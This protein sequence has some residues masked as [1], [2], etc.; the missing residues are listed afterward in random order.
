MKLRSLYAWFTERSMRAAF[1]KKR[2]KFKPRIS[3]LT[4]RVLAVNSISLL[5]LFAGLL[6]M[7]QYRKSLLQTEIASLTIQARIF[8]DT[9]GELAVEEIT[10]SNSSLM[11]QPARDVI[12]RI[13][14]P[15]RARARLFDARGNLLIDSRAMGGR[16]GKSNSIVQIEALRKDSPGMSFSLSRAIGNALDEIGMQTSWSLHHM[17]VYAERTPQLAKD[18]AEVADALSGNIQ[19]AVRRL[20]GDDDLIITVAVPVQHYKQV[21]GALMVSKTGEDIEKIMGEVWYAILQVFLFALVVTLLLS[22]YLAGTLS[23]PMV[24]LADAANRMR[25]TKNRHIQIP[26]FAARNDEIGDLSIAMRDLTRALWD[27][28]DAIERFAADVAHEI[29]NPLNSLRSAV[30]TIARIDDAKKQKQLM[31]IVLDDIARLDRLITDISEASR[32]DSDISKAQTKTIDVIKLLAPLV[33]MYGEWRK[34]SNVRVD[35]FVD[36]TQQFYV[37]GIESR[38]IQVMRNL[39]DN[40]ISFS[41]KDGIVGVH[42][43]ND[44]NQIAIS[45]TDQGPGIP[46]DRLDKIFD[47]F[48]T[49]RPSDEKFGQHSGLGLSISRQIIAAMGGTLHG[50]NIIDTNGKVAGAKF[51]VTLPR[52]AEIR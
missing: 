41:P 11:I 50:E 5:V 10:D 25:M 17:P 39:L 6:Y 33:Q 40:A 49:D 21:L 27:R 37:M 52:T 45:I 2:R 31:Q 13:V 44:R 7:D 23:R 9:L 36:P 34:K 26:D 15:T 1:A 28:L 35:L 16:K 46:N 29:K 3:P 4:K 32:V 19:S 43:D 20:D 24:K 42:I 18:Y 14:P 38:I 47:R 22:A 30:E 48:Y 8:A 12:R 51:V